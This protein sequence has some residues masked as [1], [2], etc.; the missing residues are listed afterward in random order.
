MALFWK[1]D[2]T[3]GNT[4]LQVSRLSFGT[5]YMGEQ[6]D[7]LSLET[8]AALLFAAM[9]RGVYFW[10]TSDD[11]GTH[12]YVA[13]ALGQLPRDRIVVSSKTTEPDRAVERILRELDTPYLDILF[14][15]DVEL[16]WV[17]DAREWLRLWREDKTQGKVRAL[18]FSTHSAQVAR[19]ASAWPEVEVLMVPVNPTGVT[20][21]GSSIADGGIED[22]LEAAE[23]A[24]KQGKG[25]VAMKVM[26]C[27]TLA[28][29]PETAIS[30]AAR[31]PYVHSLCIGMRSPAE[32]EQNVQLL[33]LIDR[34]RNIRE[35]P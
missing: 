15:H 8:G 19:L 1:N 26:G 2:V 29:D 23:Q 25:I 13:Y 31:L 12:Q 11:Y 20:T 6:C 32:I 28:G 10:D 34:R 33:A 4:G 27:G 17:D 35:V 24:W 7:R 5:V 30:F 18:G 21:P 3:L 14:V 9:K 16:S 22:M